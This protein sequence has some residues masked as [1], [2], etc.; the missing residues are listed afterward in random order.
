MVVLPNRQPVFAG[1]GAP[2][3]SY[4]PCCRM[5]P[6]I[7]PLS[8]CKQLIV[9]NLATAARGCSFFNSNQTNNGKK[10]WL[11]TFTVFQR[12]SEPT[13]NWFWQTLKPTPSLLISLCPGCGAESEP[14]SDLSRYVY[15]GACQN[16]SRFYETLRNC[17][18]LLAHSFTVT[19]TA[20]RCAS[21]TC[22]KFHEIGCR[23]S[24]E[25]KQC[26]KN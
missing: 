24:H 23:T 6:G 5:S 13:L 8:R 10:K 9:I 25:C 19:Y 22:F 3:R 26:M 7:A 12:M 21:L 15:S 20:K 4:N 1:V 11:G 18:S 16:S 17:V 14:G 2:V